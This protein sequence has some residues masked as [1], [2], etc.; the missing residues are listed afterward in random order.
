M[1]SLRRVDRGLRTRRRRRCAPGHLLL[2][3]LLL[4]TLLFGAVLDRAAAWLHSHGPKGGHLHL[5]AEHTDPGDLGAVHAWHDEQ[6]RHGQAGD[7][8]EDQANHGASPDGLLIELAQVQATGLRVP[9]AA[10]SL[11][12]PATLPSVL[13]SVAHIDGTRD[14][15]PRGPGGPPQRGKGSGVPRLLRTSH[16]ILI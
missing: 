13:L 6:H 11:A 7:H 3:L 10:Q 9:S 12:H 4:P 16:A 5:L 15:A 1:V 2:V 14:P 8:H